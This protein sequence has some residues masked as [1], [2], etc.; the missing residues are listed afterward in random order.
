MPVVAVL[1]QLPRLLILRLLILRPLIL[2]LLIAAI[3]SGKNVAAGKQPGLLCG[4]LGI[5]SIDFLKFLLRADRLG[6][7]A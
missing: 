6:D 1:I 4:K 2:R 7:P 3:L 5:H